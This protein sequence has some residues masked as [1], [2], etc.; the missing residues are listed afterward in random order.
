[1]FDGDHQG[2]HELWIKCEAASRSNGVLAGWKVISGTGYDSPVVAGRALDGISLVNFNKELCGIFRELNGVFYWTKYDD[3]DKKWS[4]PYPILLGLITSESRPAIATLGDRVFCLYR[5]YNDKLYCI[6]TR[7]GIAWTLPTL[8][9]GLGGATSDGPVLCGHN[10]RL[11][12]VHRGAHNLLYYNDSTDGVTWTDPARFHSSTTTDKSPALFVYNGY[13][14]CFI[15]NASSGS[16]CVSRYNINSWTDFQDLG[17]KI[18]SASQA[19]LSSDGTMIVSYTSLVGFVIN[20]KECDANG[21]WSD[22]SWWKNIKITGS[23]GMA[24][25][26][27]ALWVYAGMTQF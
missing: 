26:D 23:P 15:R 6:S 18:Y 27:G 25:W 19:G 11:V 22:A 1:M 16:L 20:F 17:S 5:G 3:R 14:H 13:L 12:A 4:S 21:N 2:K 9:A 24:N 8:A 10:D 7:D